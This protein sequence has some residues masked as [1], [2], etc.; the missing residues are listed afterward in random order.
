[1]RIAVTGAGGRLGSA[2]VAA[3]TRQAPL[4]RAVSVEAWAR[5]A[6]DLDRPD[7][8]VAL[9]RAR[10]PD[11]VL[12]TAAW[13][14]VDAC[15]RDPQTALRRN[16]EATRALAEACR[17]AGADLLYVS[18][19]EVFDGR[20][21]DRHPYAE[22]DPA[23]PANPYG[24]SKLAGERAVL[25]TFGEAADAL[26]S[27]GAS[28]P[29]DALPPAGAPPP[30]GTSRDAAGAPH[31]RAAAPR[32]WVVRTA[33][34]YGPPGDDFPA[35]I[36]RAAVRAAGEGTR[37]R[38]VA[39][40]I[41]SPTRAADLATGIVDLVR[42]HPPTGVFHLVNAGRASRAEWAEEVLREVGLRVPIER[43]PGSTWQRAS[44]PPAWAV[45]ATGRAAQHGII[46]RDW[47][48]ALFDELPRCRDLAGELESEGA[49]A[50]D[51]R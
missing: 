11:L 50:G 9:V 32:G 15:A 16:G 27:A 12:H 44:T 29:A 34:L 22:D 42:A 19:N 45:L 30:V 41:G 17:E 48:A 20:R 37:L 26:P 46:L 40:E 6:L 2:L 14:D 13:T 43:V 21:T 35:K 51:A 8:L 38:L 39:D 3:L 18:T 25:A 4:S 1:M 36:L 23:S 24:E 47:R 7:T 49:G 5:P 33:W 28:P 31:G 10:R